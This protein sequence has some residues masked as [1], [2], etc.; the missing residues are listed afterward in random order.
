MAILLAAG[1]C[2]LTTPRLGFAQTAAPPGVSQEA[3]RSV[4]PEDTLETAYTLGMGTGSRAGAMGTS[5]LAYN[6]SNMGAQR[7]YD[8]E[9]FSQLIPGDGDTY[10]TIGTSIVDSA[11]SQ[12][13]SL[14]TS[15]RATFAGTDREYDGLDWRTAIGI[16]AIEQLSLGFA[17]RW[18]RFDSKTFDGERIG[19]SFN[20]ITVDASLTITPLPFI[21]IAGLGY[22]LVKTDSPLAPQMAG[23]SVSIVP[24]ESFTA[25]FD[26]LADLSTFEKTELLLGGG[27]QFVAGE[28]VPLRIGYRRD[29]GRDLNQITAGAGFSQGKFGIE[30]SIRQTLGSQKET[31]IILVSRFVVEQ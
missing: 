9:A 31:Y 7:G 15:F 12:R 24:I 2:V 17:V 21:K 3:P 22:N 13:I 25:G 14:G 20:G 30:A 23:G 18:G 10:W 8:I 19:P 6:A 16:K 1:A 27:A 5:A 29:N 28:K 26:L 11:T 4:T